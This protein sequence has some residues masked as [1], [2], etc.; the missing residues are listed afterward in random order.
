MEKKYDKFRKVVRNTREREIEN[1]LRLELIKIGAWSIK[2]FPIVVTGL[3]DRLVIKNGYAWFVELKCPTGKISTKQ[4]NI[5]RRLI[6]YGFPVYYIWTKE[7]AN[8]F[9]SKI[10]NDL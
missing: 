5:A 4:K 8:E 7:Q 9:I 1:Y 2:L 3:P 10:N 6:K